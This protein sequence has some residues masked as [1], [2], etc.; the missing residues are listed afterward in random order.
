MK[1]PKTDRWMTIASGD[2]DGDG[3]KDLLLGGGYLPA[4]L[5]MDHRQLMDEM[6]AKGRALFVLENKAR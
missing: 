5:E 1:F 6:D 4:G 2:I 3:D